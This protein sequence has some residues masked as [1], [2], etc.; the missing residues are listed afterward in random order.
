M[1]TKELEQSKSLTVTAYE[2]LRTDILEGTL[3]PT[4]RLRITALSDRYVVGATAIREALS[5]LVSDGLVDFEDQKGFA[6]ASVSKAELLD[7][8]QTRLEVECLAARKAVELGDLDWESKMIAAFHKLSR[9][10]LPTSP[11]TASVWADAH[12]AFHES[13]VSGCKSTWLVRIC[14]LLY[15]K[16]ER[17]RNLAHRHT[18]P[19]ARDTNKE[20]KEL[21]DAALDR[22]AE[23]LC[24]LLS[25][26]F[27]KTMSIIKD[28]DF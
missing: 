5:R 26:H 3:R 15:D 24:S 1:E 10:G 4:E 16:S 21:L 27:N 19:A 12:R 18:T 22:D 14:G 8:T 20:H 11:E 7:L 2:T 28:F 23:R 17:Y 9:T 25:E 6:V 13:I